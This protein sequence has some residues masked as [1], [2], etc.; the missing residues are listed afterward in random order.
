M[1]KRFDWLTIYATGQ[2]YKNFLKPGNF[3]YSVTSPT[4]EMW[5]GYALQVAMTRNTFCVDYSGINHSYKLLS[6]PKTGQIRYVRLYTLHH[7]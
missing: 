5:F 3:Y 1:T 4:L 6:Y 2:Q 7:L